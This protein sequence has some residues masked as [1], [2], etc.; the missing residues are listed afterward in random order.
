MVLYRSVINSVNKG[1]LP[2]EN[3]KEIQE[4]KSRLTSLENQVQKKSQASNVLK[5]ILFLIIVFVVLWFLIGIY[6]YISGTN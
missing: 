4:L 2:M 5:Y 1:G 6:N 3:E